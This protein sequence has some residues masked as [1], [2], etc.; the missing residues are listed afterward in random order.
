ME[1]FKYAFHILVAS[2]GMFS[3]NLGALQ[4]DLKGVSEGVWG[5]DKRPRKN[6]CPLSL[7]AVLFRFQDEGMRTSGVMIK[8]NMQ[9][10]AGLDRLIKRTHN[11][12]G[13]LKILKMVI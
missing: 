9:G 4:A 7:T 13:S 12:K 3:I 11:L 5:D 1:C 8:D 2:D 10:R 6:S